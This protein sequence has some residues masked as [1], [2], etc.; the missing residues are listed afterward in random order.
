MLH[1]SESDTVEQ[2][3]RSND[4]KLHTKL[5]WINYFQF[6]HLDTVTYDKIVMQ[7]Q[8]DLYGKFLIVTREKSKISDW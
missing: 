5:M 6:F 7:E 3:S 2:L 1:A 4:I 8:F